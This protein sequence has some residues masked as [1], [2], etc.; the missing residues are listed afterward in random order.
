ME[1][2]YA[3]VSVGATSLASSEREIQRWIDD[4]VL[5]RS[6]LTPEAKA[7]IKTTSRIPVKFSV[8][9]DRD[10]TD[11]PPIIEAWE[12][13]PLWHVLN[14][15]YDWK[16][17]VGK[18]QKT[19]VRV[20]P[21]MPRY[22]G[23]VAE[24]LTFT[25]FFLDS[26][27][28]ASQSRV[29]TGTS[30]YL[31]LPERNLVKTEVVLCS[32][33][34]TTKRLL[35]K[36]WFDV[37]LNALSLRD[38]PKA[39]STAWPGLRIGARS[40]DYIDY[41]SDP[42]KNKVWLVPFEEP[43]ADVDFM[44]LPRW[45]SASV[46]L[47]DIDIGVDQCVVVTLRR[48]PGTPAEQTYTVNIPQAYWSRAKWAYYLSVY[49]NHRCQWVNC[50][51]LADDQLISVSSDQENR[52]YVRNDAA[53]ALITVQ[54]VARDTTQWPQRLPPVD[55]L[56]RAPRAWQKWDG[57]ARSVGNAQLTKT[58]I[59]S[60]V[61]RCL[62]KT[63]L[64]NGTTERIETGKRF[65][66]K[67]LVGYPM[68]SSGMSAYSPPRYKYFS[69][70]QVM[71][72]EPQR[73][74]F[75]REKVG[76]IHLDGEP[77]SPYEIKA[78]S[79]LRDTLVAEFLVDVD[80]LSH[81]ADFKKLFDDTCDAVARVRVGQFL[82]DTQEQDAELRSVAFRYLKGDL[83]PQALLFK[84]TVVPNALVVAFSSNKALLVS[85]NIAGP[86]WVEWQ[87]STAPG[88]PSEKLMA[89][90]GAHLPPVDKFSLTRKDFHPRKK[91]YGYHYRRFPP[92]PITF[93]ATED[94]ALELR[95][96]AIAEIKQQMDYAV[97]SSDEER[98]RAKTGMY[99]SL[100]RVVSASVIASIGPTGGLGALL[101]S[102][103]IRFV[104]N[105]SDVSF[106][107]ALAQ[108]SD[109][110]EE[111]AAY[112]NECK[113]GVLLGLV[114]LGV[115]VTV[116]SRKLRILLK[117][118]TLAAKFAVPVLNV[119]QPVDTPASV[120]LNDDS[121]DVFLLTPTWLAAM[122]ERLRKTFR[123]DNELAEL[124]G[125]RE[126][127]STCGYTQA[128]R[129]AEHLL[130]NGWEVQG[131]GLLV[132]SE[133]HDNQPQPHFALCLR[134]EGDTA[135]MDSALS[136]LDP[137]ADKR[138]Y[139][140]TLG[141]WEQYL[142]ALPGLQ[143][144]VVCY[145]FYESLAH[146][147]H[148]VDGV[149]ALGISWAGFFNQGSCSVINLPSRYTEQIHRQIQRLWSEVFHQLGPSPFD[150]SAPAQET[151]HS[152]SQA[153]LL[154]QVSNLTSLVNESE[155]LLRRT[156]GVEAVR[157]LR[158]Q[159]L[160]LLQTW[161]GEPKPEILD[162]ISEV[163]SAEAAMVQHALMHLEMLQSGLPANLTAG[164]DALVDCIDW[165]AMRAEQED[166]KWR[167]GVRQLVQRY[168]TGDKASA[169]LCAIEALDLLYEQAKTDAVLAFH[170][171]RSVS[172]GRLSPA[173]GRALFATG[174]ASVRGVDLARQPESLFALILRSQ[175]YAHDNEHFAR[176]V[177]GIS[178]L[179]QNRFA[180][181]SPAHESRLSGF[182]PVDAV[183]F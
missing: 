30:Y 90:I 114:D 31:V 47:P 99:K 20:E 131:I 122:R 22:Y 63:G 170:H 110:P 123:S 69:F 44:I 183:L 14:E 87:P 13:L 146:A 128:S 2:S 51:V 49:M 79:G 4:R 62:A 153:D 26:I 160:G 74:A 97:F 24:Q 52:W 120:A 32:V 168:V 151:L 46:V 100:V 43:V 171:S 129:C 112:I 104:A 86:K 28:T 18:W 60:L 80:S 102:G 117:Q 16:N 50:G 67:Y 165:I 164:G 159:L 56:P 94:F 167:E 3:Y 180:V 166:D 59:Q 103:M 33:W 148:E 35:A 152:F 178:A 150:N 88:Q 149:F 11:Q 36:I 6:R 78:L 143:N 91:R 71:I 77:L 92:Q 154:S 145:K 23:A 101:L 21:R 181:L 15:R 121:Q 126:V 40:G 48:L 27:R 133:L 177:Y 182:E 140:G 84:E 9:V 163:M 42:T 155:E 45:V 174:L 17:F 136:H 61:K 8:Y 19:S 96:A 125:Y 72:G 139:F 82:A 34:S 54:I 108:N 53:Q 75:Y 76:E 57:L 65:R 157:D 142:K 10:I 158:T 25:R 89:F 5:Q 127:S 70:A 156:L 124:T 116:A 29:T 73:S 106:D 130:K 41:S 162:L 141:S 68:H 109:R 115:D 147:S 98:R 37:P 118:S 111:Y 119:P 135:I 83:K 138:I 81:S 58:Y 39:I 179:R 175:P 137:D 113:L 105:I 172:Y 64:P 93:R 1:K 38:W 134:H 132:F 7:L 107:Y 85:L 176:V 66:Y 173:S 55:Q 144:K 169:S 12:E 95:Q 161:Q